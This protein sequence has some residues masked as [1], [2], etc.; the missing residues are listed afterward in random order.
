MGPLG[1]MQCVVSFSHSYNPF[2][3]RNHELCWLQPCRLCQVQN[4]QVWMILCQKKVLELLKIFVSIEKSSS[5]LRYSEALL[6]YYYIIVTLFFPGTVRHY[7][8]IIT[9]LFP[10]TVRRAISDSAA[11][12]MFTFFLVRTMRMRI[13]VIIIT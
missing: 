3:G 8:T 9:L 13:I 6:H 1:L 10:G 4:R 2:P 7:Y 12:Y 11:L 5:I